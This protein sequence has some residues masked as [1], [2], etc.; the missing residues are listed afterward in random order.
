[1]FPQTF[2]F[3]WIVWLEVRIIVEHFEKAIRDIAFIPLA[4]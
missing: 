2:F 4:Q 1:M 3:N